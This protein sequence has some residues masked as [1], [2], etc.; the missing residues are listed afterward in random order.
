VPEHGL[1]ASKSW[2]RRE[3]ACAGAALAGV[4]AVHLLA[5]PAPAGA[6]ADLGFAAGFSDLN[7]IR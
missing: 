2:P 5:A 4:V 3:Q 6:A 7:A 1:G